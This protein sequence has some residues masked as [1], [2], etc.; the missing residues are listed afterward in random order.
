MRRC[1][2]PPCRGY[3]VH[4][5]ADSVGRSLASGPGACFAD[6]DPGASGEAD[7]TAGSSFS[8][9]PIATA[10]TMIGP[11]GMSRTGRRLRPG[12]ECPPGALRKGT[13][14]EV[15]DHDVRG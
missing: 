13:S 1:L 2:D 14:D 10:A 11:A 9:H 5:P 8:M 6:A 12:V 7:V 3:S 4:R 15:H